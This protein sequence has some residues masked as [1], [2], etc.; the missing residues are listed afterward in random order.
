MFHGCFQSSVPV[1]IWEKG[2]NPDPNIKWSIIGRATSYRKGSRQYD[3]CLSEKMFISVTFDNPDYLNKRS[4]IAL[5]CRHRKKF[6]LIPPDDG[7][8]EE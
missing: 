2:M 3:L 1:D 7:E 6:L 4:E 5:R 8:D